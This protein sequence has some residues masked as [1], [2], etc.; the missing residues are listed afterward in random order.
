MDTSEGKVHSVMPFNRILQL[1][2]FKIL[3]C[4]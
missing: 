4:A 2:L 3:F 1:L